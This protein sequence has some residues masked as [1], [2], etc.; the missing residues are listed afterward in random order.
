MLFAEFSKKLDAS[1]LKSILAYPIIF[2]IIFVYYRFNNQLSPI[3]DFAVS[4]SFVMTSLTRISSDIPVIAIL[5]DLPLGRIMPNQFQDQDHT[6]VPW[7][8]A[9]FQ[10]LEKQR[11]FEIHWITLK[12]YVRHE[13]TYRVK[14][15]TIHVLPAPSLAVGLLTG[16]FLATRSL[17]RLLTALNPDL[18]HV[19][20]IEMPYAKACATIKTNKLLSY[21]GA[22]TAC[23]QRVRMKFY[24]H[25]QAFWERF[26][27][28]SYYHITCESPW[29][30]D[31]ILEIAPHSQVTLIEYGVEESFYHI[32]RLP[33]PQPECLFVGTLYEL[34]GVRYLVEAFKHPSLQH[35]RLYLAGVGK[36]R[37]ELEP[38]STPNISWLGALPRPALQ[39][40]MVS[41]WCLIHPTLADTGPTAVKEARVAGLPVITTTEAGSQ[42]H[43]VHGKSGYIIPPRDSEAI[44]K[45]VLAITESLQKNIAMGLYGLDENRANLKIQLTAHKFHALYKSLLK[46][47]TSLTK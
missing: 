4:L 11:F 13:S 9:L 38:Q 34:K 32:E 28:P 47:E 35:I 16:H 33:S 29:A 18:I 21:Q 44:R 46:K 15:Q 31:R 14:D 40:R 1:P 42:Q 43:I 5:A 7:I 24:P 25:L 8:F 22:L 36:L 39:H 17:K 3:R 41:S 20:G 6:L 19:W 12:K 30:K 26:T 37:Q 2:P 10:E 45:S 27:V 23:C